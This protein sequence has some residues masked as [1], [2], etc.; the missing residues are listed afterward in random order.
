MVDIRLIS[1][2]QEVVDT[3][4]DSRE[5]TSRGN[6]QDSNVLRVRV[7][8]ECLLRQRTYNRWMV[9]MMAL[10]RHI[11]LSLSRVVDSIV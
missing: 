2:V 8:V 9:N 10:E 3:M 7:W 11:A 5:L 6:S 1:I 4:R